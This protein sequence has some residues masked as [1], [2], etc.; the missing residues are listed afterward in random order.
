MAQVETTAGAIDASEMGRTL[1]H[2]HL[3]SASETVREQF[4]H[5]YDAT[6]SSSAPSPRSAR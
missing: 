3:L 2:E 1:A 6:A 4:P 5:L